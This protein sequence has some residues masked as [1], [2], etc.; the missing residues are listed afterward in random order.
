MSILWVNFI[1]RL[2]GLTYNNVD[3]CGIV[4]M[5]IVDEHNVDWL[6]LA[7]RLLNSLFMVCANKELTTSIHGCT[8]EV[9]VNAT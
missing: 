1:C 2:D 3:Y 4:L 5:L 9:S 7:I 8:A 6:Q